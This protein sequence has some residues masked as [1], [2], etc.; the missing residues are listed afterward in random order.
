[1]TISGFY[2]GALSLSKKKK[3]KIPRIN[4]HLYMALDTVLNK[5]R[6][7]QMKTF[8]KYKHWKNYQNLVMQLRMKTIPIISHPIFP[9]IVLSQI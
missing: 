9:F 2:L 4:T 1:M 7:S 6:E 5:T 8:R 3:K